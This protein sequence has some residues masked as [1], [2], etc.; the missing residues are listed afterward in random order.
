MKLIE[1]MT[2]KEYMVK[3]FFRMVRGKALYTLEAK[4]FLETGLTAI[5]KHFTSRETLDH[6]AKQL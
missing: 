1:T 2:G 3:V 6:Y 5:V 4:S